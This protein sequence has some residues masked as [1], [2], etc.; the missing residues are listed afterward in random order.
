[1]VR[2]V[3]SDLDGDFAALEVGEHWT[4]PSRTFDFQQEET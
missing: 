3:L 2:W 4:D 1:M